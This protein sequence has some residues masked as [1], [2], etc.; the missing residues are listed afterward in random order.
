[1]TNFWAVGASGLGKG[2]NAGDWMTVEPHVF[3]EWGFTRAALTLTLC[4]FIGACGRIGYNEAEDDFDPTGTGIPTS[5]RTGT[6]SG[7]PCLDP[8]MALTFDRTR[9]ENVIVPATAMPSGSMPRTIEMWVMNPSPPDNWSPNHSIFE[10]GG[11]NRASTFAMDFDD[12]VGPRMMELYANPAG[13]NSYFFDTG[14][15]QDTWF[16]VAAT[17]DGTKTHAFI[18]GIEVGTGFTPS[19]PLSTP[20]NQPL[21]VG[22][23][24]Y[25][26]YFTGSIDEVRVWN[27]A[28]TA[29]EIA[30]DMRLRLIGNEPGLVGYYRFDEGAGTTAL[31]AT[32]RGNDAALRNGPTYA[33]SG[34]PLLCR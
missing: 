28:R 18:D 24:A 17:W 7:T 15:K 20:P 21:Y 14:M 3:F 10:V 13:I 19:R 32:S 33:P 4:A 29:S 23:D 22:S 27:V 31:D 2:R 12:V 1:M 9:Q 16:H 30:A 26:N 34:V 11:G 6:A 8:G 5:A 25:G